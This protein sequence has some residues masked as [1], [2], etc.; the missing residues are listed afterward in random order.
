MKMQNH[1][2]D[3][4]TG[5]TSRRYENTLR[6]GMIAVAVTQGVAQSARTGERIC[7]EDMIEG[8]V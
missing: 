1:F 3:L 7:L 4:I 5:S 8:F 2:A 6:D